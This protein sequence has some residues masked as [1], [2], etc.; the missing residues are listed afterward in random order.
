M[1]TERDRRYLLKQKKIIVTNCPKCKGQDLMCFCVDK[2]RLEFRKVKANIAPKY[3]SLVFD[4]ITHPQTIGVRTR[5]RAYITNL[6]SNLENG[7][8]AFLYG[9]TGLAKTGIASIILSEALRNGHTGYFLTLDQCV[10]LYAGGW[11]DAEL[12]YK[13]Q[14]TVLGTDILVIDEL[15]NEARTNLQLVSSCLNDILRKRYNN[16]QATIITS[17]LLFG[18]VRT[19]YGDEVYS[20]LSDPNFMTAYEFKGV[21]FRQLGVTG[22]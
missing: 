2:Y 8:G 5:L 10:D 3:R 20:I 14:E 16:L 17:N 6:E 19:V 11:R 22:S 4:D 1:L 12:K 9:S 15:G 13:Y 21:D 7:H 18:K